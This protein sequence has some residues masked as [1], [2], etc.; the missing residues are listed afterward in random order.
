M[1]Q[2]EVLREFVDPFHGICPVGSTVTLKSDRGVKLAKMGYV[3]LTAEYKE[4]QVQLRW[5]N[6]GLEV[7]NVLT[8]AVLLRIPKTGLASLSVDIVGDVTGN[9]IGNVTGNVDGDLT[10]NV[11]C[12]PGEKVTGPVEG[13][14]TG[15]VTG[16]LFGK[17]STYV[18]DGP[19]ALTDS[20]AILDGNAATCAMALADGTEGQ[21]LMVKAV[22]I[23]NTCTV[24][25]T[26]FADGTSVSLPAKNDA[27]TLMF[28]G[29]NWQVINL[30]GTAAVVS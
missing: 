6:E 14:V 12:G 4:D 16:Q 3:R 7:Y 23:T 18:A 27:V 1:N 13:N 30:C 8:G 9:V 10:G 26:N 28:D 22:D 5:R 2:Y 19:I 24:T 20:M 25:P 21:A 29:T 17:V 11:T 15:N